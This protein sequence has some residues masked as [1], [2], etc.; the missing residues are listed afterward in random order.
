MISVDSTS[1]GLTKKFL[2]VITP[3]Y[4]RLIFIDKAKASGA[5]TLEAFFFGDYLQLYYF[6]V[7]LL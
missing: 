3:T 7:S 2:C 5:A 1:A 6:N 4:F